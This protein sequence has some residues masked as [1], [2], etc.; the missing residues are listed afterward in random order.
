MTVALPRVLLQRGATAIQTIAAMRLL[1][2]RRIAEPVEDEPSAGGDMLV[3]ER[4]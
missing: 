3:A 2:F 1:V 4:R